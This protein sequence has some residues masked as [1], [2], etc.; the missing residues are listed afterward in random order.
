[1]SKRCLMF[2]PWNLNEPSGSLALFLSYSRALKQDGFRL[3]CFAPR[4]AGNALSDGLF[5]NVFAAP[6]RESP[7][8]PHL[9]F[10]GSQWEDD[11]LP[12]KLGRDEAS[13]AAAGVLASVSNY[14]VVGI[15]YT[16]CHSLKQMLPPGMPAVM[17]THDL[18]SLVARQEELIFGTPARYRLEDEASRLKPFNLVTVVG[19]DDRRALQSTEPE[20][21]IV[22]APFTSAV[23]GRA[24]TVR[25][26]SPGVLLW[27]SSAAQFHRFSFIWFWKN[28][29]PTIRMSRPDCRLA[30]A[31]R[32]S[33]LA[34]QSG[35]A[36]DPRV[37]VL[38]VVDDA[39]R[40]YGEADVLIAPYYFGLGIKTKVIEALGSGIPVATTTLGIYNTHIEPG[41]DAVVS[42]EASEYAAQIVKLISSPAFRSELSQN[43]REYVRKFHDP[44]T[45]L[46]P[47]VEAF[48][49]AALSKTASPKSRA[50]A[51]SH[52]HEP[53]RQRIPEV[54][55]RCRNDGVRA[56]AI[57]GA[58]SHTRLLF[59]IWKEFGGPAITQVIVTG[60]PSET[61]CMGIPILSAGHFNPSDVDAIVLSS[62]GSEDDMAATCR[63]RWPE[64]KVYPIWESC[65][66]ALCEAKIPTALYDFSRVA[67]AESFAAPRLV[68]QPY[69]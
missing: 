49:K 64:M 10:A 38:G 37:S 1:M 59:P 33:E 6:D 31:G 57:Y 51:L 2:Y 68:T 30:I 5:E 43:G 20:M 14:D 52:L 39:A 66:Q 58:G 69:I 61:S 54:V 11:G 23:K 41:R 50:G 46:V 18:D 29:W 62:Q 47:F 53:L 36:A 4:A 21:P 44:Q 8:T 27:I 34:R 13:M 60:E 9:E 56:V 63:E 19:P 45:A 7:L 17:F 3:D 67:A 25:E 48:N 55:E 65:F 28:V 40:L 42:N 35:V 32:I 26:H 15:Q 16:R 22:E 12:E 24:A